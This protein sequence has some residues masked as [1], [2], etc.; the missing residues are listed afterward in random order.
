[1]RRVLV[2][3]RFLLQDKGLADLFADASGNYKVAYEVTGKVAAWIGENTDATKYGNFYLTVDGDETQYYIY[4]ATTKASALAWNKYAGVYA[5]TNPAD[6]LSNNTTKAIK[7][8]DTV[9]MKLVR[10]D[11]TKKNEDGTSTTTKEACGI[12]LSVNA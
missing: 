6:F 5:F 1:M 12:V 3:S 9:K 7:I 10:C 8:G 2:F 11:Y 4:G